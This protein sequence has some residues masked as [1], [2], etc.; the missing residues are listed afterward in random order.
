MQESEKVFG[1][2]TYID[3]A[4]NSSEIVIA[5]FA[6]FGNLFILVLWLC[7]K[8]LRVK[9][10]SFLI[11]LAFANILTSVLAIPFSIF[12]SK[13]NLK[14]ILKSNHERCRQFWKLNRH[15]FYFLVLL[16]VTS[17]PSLLPSWSVDNSFHPYCREFV[18][19]CH[20]NWSTDGC[21][22]TRRIS[23]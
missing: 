21:E 23:K 13:D 5:T 22:G 12:V 17:S 10:N 20:F 4:I 16:R 18:N 9:R 1:N 19:P 3:I 14:G 15:K 8:K 6:L 7:C 11:S 2:A